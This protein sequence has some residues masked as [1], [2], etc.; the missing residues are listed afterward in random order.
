Y[1]VDEGVIAAH[2][3]GHLLGAHHHY[4]NCI[5]ALPSG[6]LRGDLGPCTT[7]SPYTF[8]FSSTFGTVEEA[9]IRDYAARYAKG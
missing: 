3:I 6:A 1:Q 5:E 7:M 4:A 2:E 8:M 9:F